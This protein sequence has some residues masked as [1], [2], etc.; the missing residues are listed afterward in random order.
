MHIFA[1]FARDFFG[2]PDEET[3]FLAAFGLACGATASRT[4]AC[5]DNV[6]TAVLNVFD[7]PMDG[8][9]NLKPSEMPSGISGPLGQI[10][11][12]AQSLLIGRLDE[13]TVNDLAER[14]P[15]YLIKVDHQRR[16]AH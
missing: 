10:A 15:S 2:S 5:T 16:K 8:L 13:L 14:L 7:V 4:E 1:C 12:A 3:A 6:R 11:A 9:E